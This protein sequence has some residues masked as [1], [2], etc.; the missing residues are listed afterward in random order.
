MTGYIIKCMLVPDLLNGEG[1][2]RP[3]H[4][5]APDDS[6]LHAD[7][8]R[9]TM[10]RHV[11]YSRVEDALTRALGQ[12]IP[13][14]ALPDMAGIQLAAFSGQT[15]AGN[16][17]YTVGGTQGGFPPRSDKDGTPAVFFPYNGQSMPI[18][19]FEQYSPLRWVETTFVL[20]TEGAGRSRSSPAMRT[21]YHNPM[22]QPVNVSITS[23]RGDSDP[24]GFR[25]G[26]S[27]KRA[28][29]ESSE[30]R[31]LPVNG[32]AILQPGETVSLISATSGGYGDPEDRDPALVEQDLETGVI[33]EERAREVYGYQPDGER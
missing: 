32:P 9:A 19:V 11:T 27:G 29:V 33:S 20:D 31:S 5:S 3:I 12:T 28:A 6:I 7:R 2:F 17:F 13:D 10:A 14:M 18:E 30:D 4:V 8:P 24:S 26:H 22:E 21:S 23:D 1:I 16:E 15:P 25:G